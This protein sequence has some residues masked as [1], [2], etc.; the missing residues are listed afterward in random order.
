MTTATDLEQECGVTSVSR[1]NAAKLIDDFGKP[2]RLSFFGDTKAGEYF[3]RASW[4]NGKTHT[5]AGFAW[6][7]GGTGPAGLA[8]FLKAAGANL[9]PEQIPIDEAGKTSLTVHIMPK[10]TKKAEA[11]L[12][13]SF[14]FKDPNRAAFSATDTDTGSLP[15]WGQLVLA[16]LVTDNGRAPLGPRFSYRI[17]DAGR[18]FIEGKAP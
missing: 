12:R 1:D 10:I 16:G 2:W 14:T 8:E 5:F 11:L 17:T 3:V 15:L 13:Q 6:G 7:Y 9:T 4:P 18:A